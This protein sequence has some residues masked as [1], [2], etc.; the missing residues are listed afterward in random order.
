[1]TTPTPTTLKHHATTILT[2][3]VNDRQTAAI[4]HLLHPTITL[5]HNDLPAMSKSELIAFWPEVL[6]QSPHFR[7]QIRDVIAEGN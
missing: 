4:E 2:T 7:V 3:L 1:M 5:K 6:A